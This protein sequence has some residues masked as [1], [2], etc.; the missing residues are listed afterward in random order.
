MLRLLTELG[1]ARWYTF[2]LSIG[3][4]LDS[5]FVLTTSG[6]IFFSVM[7]KSAGLQ[8]TTFSSLFSVLNFC[9]LSPSSST[10]IFILLLI[11]FRY[12]HTFRKYSV[13][14]PIQLA[15]LTFYNNK[16]IF[17]FTLAIISSYFL[18]IIRPFFLSHPFPNSQFK[19][20]DSFRISNPQSPG[21]STIYTR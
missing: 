20:F 15:S 21:F 18:N 13:L 11:L 4:F 10:I 19:Y 12:T 3:L 5:L 8:S 6:V 1:V 7:L 2:K 17:S 16:F 9:Y 14:Y